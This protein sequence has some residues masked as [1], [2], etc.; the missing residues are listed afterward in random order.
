[1]YITHDWGTLLCGP[2]DDCSLLMLMPT[3]AAMLP[4]LPGGPLQVR[5]LGEQGAALQAAHQAAV[6]AVLERYCQ[7]RSE[8]SCYN[9]T[10]EAALAGDLPGAAGG[11]GGLQEVLD[12]YASKQQDQLLAAV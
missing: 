1:M 7:L 10:V 12:A 9:A 6:A 2:R 4:T 8:V 3:H 5:E 11:G